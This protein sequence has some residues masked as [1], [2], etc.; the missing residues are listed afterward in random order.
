MGIINNLN[1]KN[2]SLLYFALL[3]LFASSCKRIV[4]TDGE[5][6]AESDNIEAVSDAQ[7][8]KVMAMKLPLK[9]VT[10]DKIYNL[11]IPQSA[12]FEVSKVE[13]NDETKIGKI[14]N[15]DLTKLA[16]PYL[17]VTLNNTFTRHDELYNEYIV[18]FKENDTKKV[19][20]KEIKESYG[21]INFVY[22]EDDNSLVFDQGDSF[23]TIHFDYDE[24]NKSYI[25]YKSEM[26][27][28]KKYPKKQK[29]DLCLHLLKQAKNLTNHS[30]TNIPFKSWDDYVKN[31][32]VIETELVN[33]V[34]KK[35]EKELKIFLGEDEKVSPRTPGN[36]TFVS[37]YR[38]TKPKEQNFYKFVD[39]VKTNQVSQISG[40]D[41][42]SEIY[43]IN[44]EADYQVKQQEGS[45]LI[46]F[47]SKRYSGEIFKSG[48]TVICPINYKN[49]SF[50]IQ[51]ADEV[52]ASDTDIYVK[53]FSYFSK[54]YTL[55]IK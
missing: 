35:L 1:L 30:Y 31:I 7:L 42:G 44:R 22:F 51:T 20:I 18:I 40:Y 41:F 12:N 43:S 24:A 8:Q 9:T 37:L 15:V 39:A 46:D 10:I 4:K 48:V 27:W 50:F 14:G 29:V 26:S 47:S 54:N 2:T 28:S 21:E 17:Y 25:F 55:D 49:K 19:S 23:C 5:E 53:M 11:T 13:P 38:A 33:G 32:P 36:Y 3:C 45:Y 34:F 52:P 6:T 16:E